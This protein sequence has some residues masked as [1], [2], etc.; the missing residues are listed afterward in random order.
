MFTVISQEARRDRQRLAVARDDRE[1]SGAEW[2]SDDESVARANHPHP[3][4]VS[5][6]F[7]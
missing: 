4:S 2:L 5:P 3:S 1:R 7:M 6:T